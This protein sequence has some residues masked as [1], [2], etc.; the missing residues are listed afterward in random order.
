MPKPDLEILSCRLVSPGTGWLDSLS[1]APDPV[2]AEG[3]MGDGMLLDPTE[4]VLFAPCAGTVIG[5]AATGH[6]VTLR[7]PNG[8]EILMHVGVDTVALGGRGFTPRVAPGDQVRVGAPLLDFDLEAIGD[9]GKSPCIPIVL[10]NGERFKVCSR[11]AAG[12]TSAGAPLMEIVASQED[13]ASTRSG[14]ADGVT[15]A[16]TIRLPLAHGLHARPSVRLVAVAKRFAARTTLL[17]DERSADARSVASLMA[18]GA[19]LGSSVT[20][21]ARGA[22]AAEAVAALVAAIAEGLGETPVDLAVNVADASAPVAEAPLL[23][24]PLD[25]SASLTGVTGAR[26]TVIGPVAQFGAARFTYPEQGTGAAEERRRLTEALAAV[27]TGLESAAEQG[28]AEQGN[29]LAAHA[30]LLDDPALADHADVLIK[31][32]SSAEAAWAGACLAVVDQ[33]ASLGNLRLRERADDVRDV[34]GQVLAVLCGRPEATAADLAGAIVV[35]DELWPSQLIRLAAEGIAG[36]CTV[37][38]GATS[39]VSILAASR[40]IAALVATDRRIRSVPDGTPVA[41]VADAGRIE[42]APTPERRAALEQ[43]R[44]A[45]LT[46]GHAALADAAMPCHTADGARIEVFANLGSSAEA[47]KAVVGGAEGCG[48]LRSEFLFMDRATPPDED[49]QLAHYQAVADGLGDRPLVIRTLDIGGDKPVPFLSFPPEENPALG[50]RGVR[51]SLRYP[52]LLR[53]QL[54]ALLRVRSAQP[55]QIMLPMVIEQAEIAAARE[56]LEEARADLRIERPVSL[57]IMVETPAAA[58]LADTLAREAQFFSIGTNDLTQ[59]VLAIDRASVPLAQ[60]SDGLHP[61]VLRSIASVCAAG[62]ASGRSV[63]VCGAL[64]G[65]VAAMPLLI[66]LGVGRLSITAA[67]VA[68][69]KAVIRLLDLSE[70]RRVAAQ[71]IGLAAAAEVRDLVRRTWPHLDDWA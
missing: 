63:S 31:G 66:G 27:R 1:A 3:M 21:E 51:L 26:G 22:D 34:E 41:L 29:I 17:H 68:E 12:A 44:D 11:V 28:D 33:L 49:E 48:L 2:F 23:P 59:Y 56:L 4:G 57:G 7:T 55:V 52:D 45:R 71:A 14:V 54:R 69:A 16:G 10:I 64:G 39:H 67:R 46:N 35:A 15:A 18:L 13:G 19:T 8:A 58:V 38:G 32:G 6:A 20:V 30:A 25:G 70:C 36:I 60:Q 24:V 65:D 37:G 43:Q 62:A 5:V 61:A 40:G 9:A 42:I 47:A 53:T 50:L